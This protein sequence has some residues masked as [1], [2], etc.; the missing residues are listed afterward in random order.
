MG[1]SKASFKNVAPLHD[2]T[3]VMPANVYDELHKYTRSPLVQG[4]LKTARNEPAARVRLHVLV[5]SGARGV[6]PGDVGTLDREYAAAQGRN[7]MPDGFRITTKNVSAR[8]LFTD[9]DLTK[10]VWNPAKGT[11]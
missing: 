7:T 8:D 1:R 4:V 10:W 5:K 11:E 2:L 6:N 3:Q 9:G